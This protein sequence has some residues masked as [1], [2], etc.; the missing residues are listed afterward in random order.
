MKLLTKGKGRERQARDAMI[1][2]KARE[3]NTRQGKGRYDTTKGKG[4]ERKARDAMKLRKTI[5]AFG[6]K[7]RNTE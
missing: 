4:R 1:L 3:V 5:T 2:R 6:Y 7:G